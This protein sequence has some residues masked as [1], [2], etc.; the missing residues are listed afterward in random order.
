MMDFTT[1]SGK[2]PANH[3]PFV[4]L[5]APETSLVADLYSPVLS[6]QTAAIRLNALA[7]RK[8]AT[9]YEGWLEFIAH[10][11]EEEAAFLE[12]IRL[13]RDHQTL[14]H[15]CS[16]FYLRASRDYEK[17]FLDVGRASRELSNEMADALQD[18]SISREAG[19]VMGE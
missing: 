6:F 4:S 15:A 10:R 18:V 5:V 7:F 12:Q 17:E 3:D 19:A 8:W 16:E 14:T 11:L 13:A 9:G 1:S 2:A